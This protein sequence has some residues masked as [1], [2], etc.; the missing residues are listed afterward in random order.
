MSKTTVLNHLAA[1]AAIKERHSRQW[2]LGHEGGA[3]AKAERNAYVESF[4]VVLFD[5]D[6]LKVL[7]ATPAATGLWGLWTPALV[8]QLAYDAPKAAKVLRSV[9]RDAIKLAAERDAEREADPF[10]G[11]ENDLTPKSANHLGGTR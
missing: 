2:P 11:L 9:A 5:G 7:Q 3:V 6:P 8:D 10:A 4:L 1:R